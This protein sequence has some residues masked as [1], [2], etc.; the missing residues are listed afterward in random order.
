MSDTPALRVGLIHRDH[1]RHLQHRMIGMWAY[2]V[3]QFEVTRL[4]QPKHFT[5]NR[6]DYVDQFDVLFWEDARTVGTIKGNAPIPVVYYAG[7]STLTF[8]HLR[9][10]YEQS[11]Q[12]DLILVDWDDL[13]TFYDEF[14]L[15]KR[16]SY[17]VN[18]RLFYPHEKTVDVGFYASM[19][20]ERRELHDWLTVFCAARGYSYE[21]GQREGVAYCA[22]IGSARVN[23]NM[24]RNPQTRAHRC[25]DVMASGSCLITSPM[26]PVSGEAWEEGLHYLEWIDTCD[27]GAAIEAA[28]ENGL[29]PYIAGR[30]FNYVQDHTWAARATQLHGLLSEF[31]AERAVH[32]LA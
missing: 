14:I 27:L 4:A 20:E 31:I 1:P 15:V 19:T 30:A 9:H 12:A 2:E 26:P 10:R 13:D 3:P 16:L 32:A 17:C 29:W 6:D 11:R 8:D 22:A 28:L 7:D 18:E 25:F 21:G 23:I 24:N 5:L